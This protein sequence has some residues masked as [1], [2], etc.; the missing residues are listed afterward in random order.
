MSLPEQ[1]AFSDVLSLVLY[2]PSWAVAEWKG[3]EVIG[4]FQGPD[5]TQ[6]ATQADALVH[7]TCFMPTGLGR[8]AST[9]RLLE[10]LLAG[11]PPPISFV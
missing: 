5:G 9:R 8:G 6:Q 4:I 11:H 10:A 3:A 2:H 7:L 1:T